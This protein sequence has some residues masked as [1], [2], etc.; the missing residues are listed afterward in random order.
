MQNFDNSPLKEIFLPEPSNSFWIGNS[1][2]C[3]T[4]L[5]KIDILIKQE[6]RDNIF[7]KIIELK[8][9]NVDLKTINERFSMYI[10]W[11]LQYFVP[12]Y[13]ELKKKIVIIPCLFNREDEC[14]NLLDNWET[15]NS[16]TNL[17][18]Y[19]PENILFEAKGNQ[20]CFRKI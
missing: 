7:I 5:E 16:T 3:G 20:V 14:V 10:K 19:K 4:G 17:E 6:N 1:V 12:S 15:K 11:V 8:D 18:I 2:S 13:L 9:T